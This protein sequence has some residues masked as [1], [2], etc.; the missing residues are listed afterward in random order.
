MAG[1]NSERIW[2]CIFMC[3]TRISAYSDM[4]Q[5]SLNGYFSDG[6]L[7]VS[8]QCITQGSQAGVSNIH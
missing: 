2:M 1:R 8:E 4:L 3:A 6:D 7:S 5:A